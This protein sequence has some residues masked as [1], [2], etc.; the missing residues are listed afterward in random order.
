MRLLRI[1]LLVVL[2]LLLPLRGAVAAAMLCQ[3]LAAGPAMH[4]LAHAGQGHEACHQDYGQ[5]TQDRC[6]VCAA[7][8]ALTPLPAAGSDLPEPPEAASA[9]FPEPWLPPASFLSGGQER[10]PRTA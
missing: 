8:C 2:A 10:P 6:H 9:A 5:A 7:F 1:W 4:Q 3:P